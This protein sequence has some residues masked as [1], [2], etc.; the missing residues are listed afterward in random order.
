MIKSRH[1]MPY[2]LLLA[3]VASVSACQQAPDTSKSAISQRALMPALE[4][5]Y[6]AFR[7]QQILA[8]DYQLAVQLEAERSSFTASVTLDFELAQNN[9]APVTIDFY[10][11]KIHR[12]VVNGQAVAANYD[13]W[14]I[15]LAPEW[16]VA[17]KNHVEIDYETEY[18]T[19]GEG[20]HRYQDQQ[21]GHVYLYTNF[22]P[23][24]ANK[25]FPHFDQPNL[26][27]SYLLTVTAPAQWQVISATRETEIRTTNGVKQWIFPKTA[28]IPSYIFPLH[29]GDYTLWEDNSGKIPLRLFARQELAKY[30]DPQ[31]W[32]TYTQKSF[33]FFN[34][35]FEYPY[36][37]EKYDQVIAPEFNWGAMENVGA[38]IFSEKFI[39]RGQRTEAER[40]SLSSVIAHEMAHMWFG[41]LTTME[42]WNGLWLNES[43]ATYMSYLA[44]AETN[45]VEGAWDTFYAKI[46]QWAY[47]TDQQ[48]TTHAIELPVHTT[49]DAFSNFDG[50]TY[51]KGASALK[52]LPHYLGEENFRRG[53]ATYLK[54]HAYGNTRL[55]DFMSAL[56][57]AADKDLNG[58]TQQWLFEIGLNSLQAN[59]S[60]SA[61]GQWLTQLSLA[62]TAPLE[63]PALREQRVQVGL[64]GMDKNDKTAKVLAKIPVTYQG[65]NTV[66]A[67]PPHTPCPDLIYP[68]LDDWGYVKVLLDAQSR[69][70]LTQHLAW[71]K[72][73]TLRLM[74]WE[75][76]WDAVQDAKL[77]LT[78]H[79]QFAVD[80]LANE[81]NTKTIERVAN[82]LTW[83]YEYYTVLA[84]AQ[85]SFQVERRA[86]ESF[87]WQQLTTRTA[88]TDRQKIFFQ[89]F[90]ATAHSEPALAYLRQLLLK[91]KI[92]TGLTIDQDLRWQMLIR[93]NQFH[94]RDF[95]ALT[96]TEAKN[97][98]SQRGIQSVYA[99]QAARPDSNIKQRW[100]DH[101][102][103]ANS[104]YNLDQ[105]RT[106]M[107]TLFPT[108]QH[109][110][111]AQLSKVII[112]RT[113]TLD[114]NTDDQTLKNISTYLAPNTCTQTSAAQLAAVK[115]QL[116]ELRA[117]LGKNYRIA[118]YENLRCLRIGEQLQKKTNSD[119][120]VPQ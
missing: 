63:Y 43:F 31:E 45:Q 47:V 97:D 41:N 92:I 78:E 40:I 77:P 100:L 19:L 80:N 112:D 111:L 16:L 11:G 120:A 113:Q 71:F 56:G 23:F 62:Q 84:T 30:V 59:F 66:V 37:F 102:F 20:L 95:A 35:Y 38:V 118:H 94:Y 32:F 76:L 28:N 82:T 55:D 13:K 60:C 58:W 21:T 74:L 12:L 109:Q 1:W 86:I 48:V 93:L 42:W 64:F 104:E 3:L 85:H 10:S 79:S 36:P 87:F 33:A 53:V 29:A 14:F 98:A 88:E 27:A 101:I 81:T 117:I 91:Q 50:I 24:S 7:K 103:N 4:A 119:G 72:D 49:S 22:E 25:F 51:G 15:T 44:L 108:E 65:A 39:T 105:L 70:T 2:G 96:Q 9:Q 99:A 83:G 17:G 110:L 54:Q 52:Q 46:K 114:A 8:V 67:I 115:D 5:D 107:Q 26:K 89:N 61:D 75:T 18:S 73:D 68:N 106:V 90:I 34:A 116:T 57:K 69:T 6:A